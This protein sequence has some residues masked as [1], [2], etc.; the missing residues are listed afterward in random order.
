MVGTRRLRRRFAHPTL[1]QLIR[2]LGVRLLAGLDQ[3]EARLDL[4]DQSL[5]RLALVRGQTGHDL[6]L[7]LLQTRDQLLI[8]RLALAGQSQ[9]EFA[10]VIGVLDP[11]DQPPLQQ[12]SDGTADRRF[13]RAGACCDILR[14]AGLAAKTERRQHAPFRNIES[15]A[16]A[17]VAGE[18]RADLGGQTIEP[19]W[20]ELEQVEALV[21]V[22]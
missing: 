12:R 21:F 4:A 1:R 22:R 10:P 20:R 6:A 14:A 18:R 2:L 7:P 15:V 16:L 8:E 13:V 11:L 17:I 9:A 5:E 19:E 3:I